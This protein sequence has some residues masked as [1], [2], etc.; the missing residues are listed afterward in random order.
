MMQLNEHLQR[1]TRALSLSVYGGDLQMSKR[2]A[3][4]VSPSG[5]DVVV[6]GSGG[7]R[8]SMVRWWAVLW[9]GG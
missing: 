1:R 5:G 7:R 2:F 8:G 9:Y 3:L 6:G 4:A